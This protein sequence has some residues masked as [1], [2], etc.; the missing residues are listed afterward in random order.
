MPLLTLLD[1]F[2]DYLV[3]ERGLSPNTLESYSRDLHKYIDYLK[4]QGIDD[5]RDS[6]SSHIL[7][8]I[9]ILTGKGL[10]AKTIARN[11]AAVRMFYRFLVNENYLQ[12]NPAAKIDSPKTW[13]RLPNTISLDEV[14]RLLDQPDTNTPLGMRDSAMLELLYATGM[15]VSELISIS[16]N[17]IN[18]E[19]GYLIALGKGSKE[20]IL[21]IG[22]QAVTKVREYL[23]SSR[24]RLLKNSRSSALFVNR[25]GN[26]ISRQ[27]FWKVIK[28]YSLKAGIQKNIT[29]HTLRHSFATHLLER[30][31]DLRSVQSMLG[32]VDISTTQ[33]Y[34]HVTR[35]RLKKLHS[36]LHPRA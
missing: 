4:K 36:K 14:E 27:G 10:S 9:S 30:G 19:V 1:E 13:I 16:L 2:L 34:T 17:H 18:L 21:P 7:V 12:G 28:K 25:S 6:S 5:I 3:V 8:F 26:P 11:L 24:K 29:P 15:R 20:R 23:A 32:H 35:E 22:D 33:I 31:A